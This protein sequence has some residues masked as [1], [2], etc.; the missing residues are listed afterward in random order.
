ML[1]YCYYFGTKTQ[2]LSKKPRAQ[3]NEND[4]K[5]AVNIA[6]RGAVQSWIPELTIQK[7]QVLNI[8][9]DGKANVEVSVVLPDFTSTTIRV[10]SATLN[11]NGT[12][13]I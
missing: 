4:F 3:A 13:S 8:S 7:I 10:S 9:E 12:V 2:R 6:I 5:K 11:P 1:M